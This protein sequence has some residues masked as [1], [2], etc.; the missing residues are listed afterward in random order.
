MAVYLRLEKDKRLAESSGGR[1][2]AGLVPFAPR[3]CSPCE[4]HYVIVNSGKIA[5]A[6]AR[7]PI[8]GLTLST[9]P[10]PGSASSKV[11]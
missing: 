2:R 10:R 6:M 3:Y 9:P 1:G 7:E 5:L 8:A 11:A 4:S